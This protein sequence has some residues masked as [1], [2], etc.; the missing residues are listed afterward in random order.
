MN[1]KTD[2]LNSPAT[3]FSIDLADYPNTTA[4]AMAR[5]DLSTRFS[6]EHSL[7]RISALIKETAKQMVPYYEACDTGIELTKEFVMKHPCPASAKYI[8]TGLTALFG[9]KK[10]PT[11]ILAVLSGESDDAAARKIR[12]KID[13]VLEK[14]PDYDRFV[15]GEN[16]KLMWIRHEIFNDSDGH[17]A[18]PAERANQVRGMLSFGYL[19]KEKK[20]ALCFSYLN[21]FACFRTDAHYLKLFNDLL[22]EHKATI[23]ERII[24]IAKTPIGGKK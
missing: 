17:I 15:R 2:S 21:F 5:L 3:D 19:S 9:N 24:E 13:R 14:H 23:M 12:R 10:T 11:Q 4:Y 22:G 20:I 6:E 18:T 16:I 8:D 7:W 1:K